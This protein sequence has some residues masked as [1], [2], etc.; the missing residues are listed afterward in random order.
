[1]KYSSIILV[2]PM[3]AGKTSVGKKLAQFTKRKFIDTDQMIE[4]QQQRSIA[5][6]IN[7]FGEDHFRNL[8]QQTISKIM[9]ESGIVLA[10]GGG[11][12]LSAHLRT[13]LPQHGIV[14]YLQVSPTQQMFRLR[15]DNSRPLI[16][17]E[18]RLQF[19][20]QMLENRGCLYTE[21]AD[22][23][24]STDNKSVTQIVQQISCLVAE[25]AEHQ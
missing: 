2:G 14:C 24:I 20:T 17:N 23:I 7:N 25:Y 5:D 15:N 19:F 4:L 18:Q 12:V 13:L 9:L 21:I 1:M 6:I 10:T 11:S 3:G 22:M 16:P 8:E